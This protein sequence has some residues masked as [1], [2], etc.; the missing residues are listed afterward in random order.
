VLFFG[1]LANIVNQS[2]LVMYF[3]CFIAAHAQT[4]AKQ[5]LRLRVVTADGQTPYL[6]KSLVR[7]LALVFSANLLFLPMLYVFF[8]PERR[9]LHDLL[10][11]TYVVEV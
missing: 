10:A 11:G 1:N 7:A 8:N 5:L 3:T 6:A 4:P 2:M 9:G